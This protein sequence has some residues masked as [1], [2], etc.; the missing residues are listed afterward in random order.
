MSFSPLSFSSSLFVLWLS[1]Q[2]LLPLDKYLFWICILSLDLYSFHY[3]E[4]SMRTQTFFFFFLPL[5]AF[6]AYHDPQ[7]VFGEKISI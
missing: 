6:L 2:H 5:R 1:S 4:S 3:N 7:L